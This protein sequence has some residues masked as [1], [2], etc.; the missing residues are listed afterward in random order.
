MRFDTTYYGQ[1]GVT[2]SPFTPHAI[3]GNLLGPGQTIGGWPSHPQLA[4]HFG[5]GL[6]SLPGYPQLAGQLG[7]FGQFGHAAYGLPAFAQLCGQLGQAAHV[8]PALAQLG[9]LPWQI[10][11]QSAFGSP[12]LLVAVPTFVPP[13]VL[14]QVPGQIG[15]S[16]VPPIGWLGQSPLAGPLGVLGPAFPTPFAQQ[17]PFA[18][19][20]LLAQLGQLAQQGMFGVPQGAFGPSFGTGVSG[21]FGQRGFGAGIGSPLAFQTTPQLAYAG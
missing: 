2:Q 14:G 17:N 8:W 16:L 1:P 9:V 15:Q 3:P 18:Q 21:A 6:G 4:G 20:A 13:G 10:A 11:Q 5:Q 12:P 7:Q 19:Q